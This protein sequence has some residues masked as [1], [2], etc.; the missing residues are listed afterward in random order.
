MQD[1]VVKTLTPSSGPQSS[2]QIAEGGAAM[3]NCLNGLE[4]FLTVPRGLDKQTILGL[5]WLYFALL[6]PSAHTPFTLS[7]LPHCASIGILKGKI[8]LEK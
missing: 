3:K 8:R 7:F 4:L 6:L 2:A 1:L 5:L